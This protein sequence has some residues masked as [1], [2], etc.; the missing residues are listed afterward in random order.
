MLRRLGY[1]GPTPKPYVFVRQ[2]EAKIPASDFRICVVPGSKVTHK[3]RNK[4]WPYFHLL[5]DLL[6]EKY[7]DAQICIVGS[8]EDYIEGELSEDERIID[9]RGRL[10]WCETGWVI[11]NSNLAIGND[12]GPVHITGA[13]DSPAVIIFGPTCEIKNAPAGE[14]VAVRHMVPCCPCQYG[15]LLLTCENPVC[16][17]E[18]KPQDI[19]DCTEEL[20]RR[21][22]NSGH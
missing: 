2:P 15:R 12:C 14:F 20:L 6:L 22:Q 11:K 17:T 16:M 19:L 10:S 8:S 21:V 18:L 4:R 7:P 9:L 3:W 5:V 13:T 1:D